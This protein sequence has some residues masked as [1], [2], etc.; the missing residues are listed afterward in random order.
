MMQT[1]IFDATKE[2]HR[3]QYQMASS[4]QIKDKRMLYNLMRNCENLSPETFLPVYS[5]T[6]GEFCIYQVIS[7]TKKTI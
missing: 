3:M 1:R 6:F 5:M 7:N 4:L 2:K